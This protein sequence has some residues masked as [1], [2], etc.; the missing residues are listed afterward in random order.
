[1]NQEAVIHH[2]SDGCYTDEGGVHAVDGLQ[3]HSD[4]KTA[5]HIDLNGK[6]KY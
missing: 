1:M 3:L 6:Q 5:F 2:I 4:L